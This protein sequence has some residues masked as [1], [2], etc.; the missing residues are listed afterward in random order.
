MPREHTYHVVAW[1]A[2]GRTGIAKSDS[3]PTAIHFTAPANFGGIPDRWT[4]EDLLLCAVASCFTTTFHAVAQHAKLEY[5]DLQ[6]D[7]TAAVNRAASGYKISKIVLTPTLKI[8]RQADREAA[9]N[10]LKKTES[11]CLVARSLCT[12]QKFQPRIAVNGDAFVR[13]GC[14]GCGEGTPQSFYSNH[15]A[16]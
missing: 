7:A 8:C 13:P 14:E 15:K 11:L 2:A 12:P 4:P 16:Q 6:V 5:G 10:L 3:A 1:W 9:L